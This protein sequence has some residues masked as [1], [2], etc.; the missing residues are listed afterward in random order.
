M[1][2]GN[3]SKGV[4][5]AWIGCPGFRYACCWARGCIP[6]LSILRSC[7]DPIDACTCRLHTRQL[8]QVIPCRRP[9]SAEAATAGIILWLPLGGGRNDAKDPHTRESTVEGITW[10][11]C[12]GRLFG[13]ASAGQGTGLKACEDEIGC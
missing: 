4:S 8:S 2:I 1:V 13:V 11:S 9:G 7:S 6:D 12:C 5:K 10:D 3:I